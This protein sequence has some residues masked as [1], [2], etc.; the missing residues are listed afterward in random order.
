[1]SSG[2]S[3]AAGVPAQAA[4]VGYN[5]QTFGPTVGLGSNWFNW[6][7][8]GSGAQA[9]GA[10]GSNGGNLLLTGIENDNYGAT[11]ASA[12]QIAGG[13][14]WN[15]SAF[16]GGGYFEA[17]LS[18]T[19]Q[20]P[21][22]YPN[23]GPAFWLLDIEHLSQ[24]PY[25]IVWPAGPSGCIDYFEVDA[26]EYDTGDTYGYQNGIATWY[27]SYDGSC[28]GAT[29]NP[30]TQIPGAAGGVLTPTGTDFTQPHRYG[31][32]WVPAT[33]SGDTTYTQGYMKFYF[34]GVQVGTTFTWNYYDP[35]LTATYPALPP[36][37]GSSAMSGMDY[38][39]MTLI[40]GTG[41]SQ[42][43]TVYGV[44]V[45]QKSGASNLSN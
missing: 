43:M 30:N 14:G 12:Q 37:N 4:A 9:A 16:G 11:I 6:N 33:G 1:M 26:M 17:T 24:G 15:G 35:T 7:F 19:G 44:N 41:T 2:T 13:N 5:T 20:G 18:F 21:G 25:N 28:R 34:D 8:Y 45:W 42:P 27:N 36:V 32:L 22:P 29:Y 39:H 40:L 23:G 10:T 3:S 31:L 38:R